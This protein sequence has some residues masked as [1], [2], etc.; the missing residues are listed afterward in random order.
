MTTEVIYATN[1]DNPVVPV[2]M[3]TLKRKYKKE[4]LTS[5]ALIR[6]SLVW[7]AE[8]QI[9]ALAKSKGVAGKATVTTATCNNRSP[10]ELSSRIKENDKQFFLHCS[11]E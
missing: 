2:Q 5:K 3:I 9:R 1:E 10:K 6:S 11:S 4:R 8:I 7:A